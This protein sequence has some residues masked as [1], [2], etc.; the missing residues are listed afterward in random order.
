[1]TRFAS[2]PS[3]TPP[4]TGADVGDGVGA[5]DAIGALRLGS[6]E[7]C[8]AGDGAGDAMAIATARMV[9]VSML[10]RSVGEDNLVDFVPEDDERPM[11]TFFRPVADALVAPGIDVTYVIGT[12]SNGHEMLERVAKPDAVGVGTV[13]VRVARSSD[14][15]DPHLLVVGDAD[16]DVLHFGRPDRKLKAVRVRTA[17]RMNTFAEQDA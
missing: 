8:I 14:Q 13:S 6:G 3:A 12:S 4:R 11:D 7:G 16:E 10:L 1:M 5:G 15:D 9:G 2:S 17:A